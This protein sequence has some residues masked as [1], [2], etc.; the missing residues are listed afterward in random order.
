MTS[1][2]EGRSCTDTQEP[3]RALEEGSTQSMSEASIIRCR[4]KKSQPNPRASQANNRQ[5][6]SSS[7][8]TTCFIRLLQEGEG[9]AEA[10]VAGLMRL[11]GSHFACFVV[12]TRA[13]QKEPITIQSTSKKNFLHQLLNLPS[14]RWC[15]IH[16]HTIHRVS[17]SMFSLIHKSQ[18]CTYLLLQ[19]L[20]AIQ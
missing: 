4:L 7:L 3:A 18:G 13:T 2:K 5:A 8:P 15:S 19:M 1:T 16:F 11:Q 17:R 10:L 14:R 20:E 6:P 9:E 12:R